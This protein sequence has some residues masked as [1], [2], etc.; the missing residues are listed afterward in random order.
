[1]RIRDAFQKNAARASAGVLLFAVAGAALAAPTIAGVTGSSDHKGSMTITGSGF[2][3]K[4][5]AAP[6]VWD[7]ASTGTL[8]TDGGKWHG[9]YP[10]PAE[11]SP[12]YLRYTTPIRNIALPHSHI[13]RYIAG[14]HGGAQDLMVM[15]WRNRT[16]GA[17]PQYTY[18][19]WYQRGDDKWVFGGDNNYKMYDFSVGT[20]PYNGATNWYTAFEPPLPDSPTALAKWVVNDDCLSQACQSLAWPDNNGNNFFWDYGVNPFSGVWSKIEMEIKWT[21]Q[22]NGYV[23]QWQDGVLVI[24]Y[25]G[26]TDKYGGTARSESVGGYARNYGELNNWRYWADVYLDYS[27]ARVVLADKTPLSS[28]KI[29]EVQLATNWSDG[30][31]SVSVNLGKFAAA[32]TAYVFVFDPNGVPNTVGFPVTIG[33]SSTLQKPANLRLVP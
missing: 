13:S 5:Q 23:K 3:S 15:F 4:P 1:M 25:S 14:G 27:P 21:N 29:R 19:S 26:P 16:M 8:V 6:V 12:T 24:N 10:T 20:R 22:S 18:I 11:G 17:F 9:F 33:G 31:I 28:A 2:G 7:D 30:S 32:Q